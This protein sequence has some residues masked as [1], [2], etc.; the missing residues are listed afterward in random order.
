MVEGLGWGSLADIGRG[1]RS[2]WVN[3]EGDGSRPGRLGEADGDRNR[4]HLPAE[5]CPFLDCR[6]S[7]F[8][9][10]LLTRAQRLGGLLKV[11]WSGA[12][13]RVCG[14]RA[15]ESGMLLVCSHVSPGTPSPVLV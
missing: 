11:T 7:P 9:A 4:W 3:V 14:V 15:V 2:S 8:I 10:W 1:S 5:S 6:M 12:C 13:F